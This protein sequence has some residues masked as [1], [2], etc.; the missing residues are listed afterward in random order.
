MEQRARFHLPLT[1]DRG[2]LDHG[3]DII[4]GIEEWESAGEDGQEYDARGPDVDF[5]GLLCAFEEDFGG[6]EASRSG[7][8]C[9]PRGTLVVFGVALR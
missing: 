6:A 7:S 3:F 5:G 8:V 4:G 2:D 1:P 9:S